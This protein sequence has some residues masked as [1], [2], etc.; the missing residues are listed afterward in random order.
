MLNVLVG[1]YCSFVISSFFQ[2]N[3]EIKLSF[4]ILFRR[5][6]M[7]NVLVDSYCS[8]SIFLFSQNNTKIN[9]SFCI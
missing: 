5:I 8:F 9:L 1:S 2:S 3:A 6:F 7:L 4:C